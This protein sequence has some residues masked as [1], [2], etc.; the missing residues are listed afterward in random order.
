M[1]LICVECR[2]R[3]DGTTCKHGKKSRFLVDQPFRLPPKRSDRKWKAVQLLLEG[4]FRFYKG[5]AGGYPY[6]GPP[7]ESPT[8]VPA[9]LEVFHEKQAK[10]E[11]D[12]RYWR[13]YK[14]KARKERKKRERRR[15]WLR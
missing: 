7:P 15:R 4:G 13:K 8:Q 1:K 14:R 9:F 6:G 12:E 11:M 3:V 2:A 10:R 5:S